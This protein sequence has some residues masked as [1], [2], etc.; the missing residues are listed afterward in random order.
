MNDLLVS[1]FVFKSNSVYLTTLPGNVKIAT[2]L[3]A[4]ARQLH[5]FQSQG[6]VWNHLRFVNKCLA[7]FDGINEKFSGK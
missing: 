3:C 5:L 4:Q 1:A 7:L 6:N 2:S